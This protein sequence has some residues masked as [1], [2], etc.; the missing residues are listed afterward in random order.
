MKTTQRFIA[1]FAIFV[2]TSYFNPV[3]THAQGGP[4]SFQV[5]YDNLSPYGQWIDMPAHGYVWIPNVGPGFA[6]YSTNGYWANTDMGWTWVSNYEWGW[7]PFHYGRW[8]RDY[9]LGWFWVPGYEW[10]PAW[11]AWRQSPGYYGWAPLRPGIEIGAVVGGT[12]NPEPQ[13]WVFAN[14]RYM[15]DRYIYNYYAPREDNVVIINRSSYIRETYVDR[16]YGGTTYMYGPGRESVERSTNRPVERV[17]LVE[18]NEP[19]HVVRGNEISIYRPHVENRPGIRPTQVEEIRNVRPERERQENYQRSH[20]EEHR[21]EEHR[22]MEH[23]DRRTEPEHINQ[24]NEQRPQ[25][26]QRTEPQQNQQRTQPQQNQQ[27][28]QPQQNQ[29]QQQNQQKNQTQPNNQRNKT[30]TKQQKT[31]PQPKNQKQNTQPNN[32]GSK[33]NH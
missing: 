8:D 30:N 27:M 14:E 33:Q 28:N 15:G 21:M 23:N 6:P 19:G 25:Q 29:Q 3:K 26:N 18:R 4:V 17:V 24:P 10:A 5:F 31:L 16:G 2:I 7:A 32:N 1:I 12:Y 9:N 20:P 11:V 13:F 22:D